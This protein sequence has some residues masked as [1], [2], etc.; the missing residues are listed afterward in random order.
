MVAKRRVECKVKFEEFEVLKSP[1]TSFNLDAST[2]LHSALDAFLASF[3]DNEPENDLSGP[4]AAPES[5]KEMWHFRDP[6]AFEIKLTRDSDDKAS[7]NE[8]MDDDVSSDGIGG[9]SR[10]LIHVQFPRP[11]WKLADAT[12]A[13]E[14]PLPSYLKLRFIS[15]LDAHYSSYPWPSS[16]VLCWYLWSRRAEICSQGTIKVLELGSGVGVCGVLVALINRHVEK[17]LDRRDAGSEWNVTLTDLASP[18]RILD[19]LRQTV[20]LNAFELSD[21]RISV[22]PL[23][24]GEFLP[25][26]PN[27]TWKYDL[28]IASDVFYQPD[29]FPALLL[30]I[31]HT[32]AHHAQPD[33]VVLTSYQ[34]RS[35]KRDI[36]V[37]LEAYGLEGRV[38]DWEFDEAG[39]KWV[40]WQR[41]MKEW[42]D[43]LQENEDEESDIDSS[44]IDL[45]DEVPSIGVYSSIVLLELRL[46]RPHFAAE[47]MQD[48]E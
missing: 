1:E 35:S 33:A 10:T 17:W 44:E 29:L 14:G 43:R 27:S 46:K 31:S 37:L 25:P 4:S 26:S 45:E 5:V 22:E 8:R 3:K 36:G 13:S 2:K 7:E 16:H 38:L 47:P 11:S 24:W 21:P 40:A 20:S 48:R 9:D 23:N 19:N 42:D 30:T 6:D 34:E 28:L 41:A 39:L 32:L 15:S 18:S 12:D